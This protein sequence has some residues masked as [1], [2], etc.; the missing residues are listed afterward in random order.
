METYSRTSWTVVL[1]IFINLHQ[2][3]I[4]TAAAT[5]NAGYFIVK[6]RAGNKMFL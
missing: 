1:Y 2:I 6:N 3:C 4:K 5:W